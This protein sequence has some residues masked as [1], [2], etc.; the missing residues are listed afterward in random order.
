MSMAAISRPPWRPFNPPVTANTRVAIKA[1][2]MPAMPK[3]LPKRAVSCRDNP[4][5]ARMN[6][7][8]ATM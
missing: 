7:N 8:A 4:A 2:A 1:M 3:V 6:S 5:R